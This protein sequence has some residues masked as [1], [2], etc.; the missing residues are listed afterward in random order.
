VIAMGK[1]KKERQK[2]KKTKNIGNCS[3][4]GDELQGIEINKALPLDTIKTLCTKSRYVQILLVL[5]LIGFFLRFY[6]LGLNSLWL[7]E[8]STF[9]ISQGSFFEIWQVTAGGE[10]N[11][12][13]FYWI[14]HIMLL[15]GNS[16]F[17]L[18]FIPALLGALTIPLVYFCGK[19]FLDRNC[20]LIAAALIAFSP[21]H[22]FYSQEARAYSTMLFFV[23]LAL[24]F[25]LKALKSDTARDWILFGICSA[26]GF[27]FHFYAFVI[28]SALMIYTIAVRSTA[29][30]KNFSAIQPFALGVIAFIIAT[31]PLIV[32]TVQLFITRTS[33][34]PTYGI[35]GIA[36]IGET[37]K[38]IS[39]FNEIGFYIL[40]SLFIVGLISLF[41]SE[42]NKVILL[43]TI[44][45]LTFVISFFLSF[46][47]P[48]I[49]RYLIFLLPVYFVGI[50]S[51]YQLLYRII[52]SPAI[53]YGLIVICVLISA[54][55]LLSYY[56]GM[57]KDDWR[58]FA[59]ALQSKTQNGDSIVLVP[60]YMSQ[61]F[62]YYYSNATD[63]TFEYGA[64]TGNELQALYALKENRTMYFVVTSDIAAANPNGDA[65]AW[66][67]AH[68]TSL[69]QQTGII[70]LVAT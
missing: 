5:T 56:S 34:A 53:V 37:L 57:S 21:F 52:Q 61:P 31:V 48:M 16:E 26:L 36:I 14:E 55:T 43:I 8:A 54:P 68:T 35:Q 27:W 51:S 65:V 11:P 67:Q 66:L 58:G 70:L 17:V 24:I 1:G 63:Q 59:G 38:Q 32:V 39:G 41:M 10:F 45:V 15:F 64:Y 44:I 28:I 62:N 22:I 6:N 12:P 69:G 33:S 19:E 40:F 46:K 29:I 9:S 23:A 7:D 42:K 18:R 30:V 3:L 2:D 47:M 50:A 4:D 49:P 25:Y 13:L 60:G 20:G